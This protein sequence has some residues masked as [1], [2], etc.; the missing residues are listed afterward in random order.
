VPGPGKTVL[1]TG[2][3]RGIG[4]ACAQ[5]LAAAGADLVLVDICADLPGVDYPMGSAG[6][7]AATA[8]ECRQQGVA[9]ETVTGDVRDGPT[10]QQAA[11]CALDRFG[12]IDGLVNC[13]GIAGPSG[14]PVYEL[15]EPEWALPIGV[16]L[17]GAWQL[18]RAVA[19]AMVRQRAGSIVNIASTAGLVGYRHFAGYVAS[20][21]GL[22][23]LTKAA[24]L[25]LAPFGVR[26]NAVCPGSVRD[27][28]LVDGRML[29]AVA[30]YLRV[31]ADEYES[32]F[33][34]Q[35][36]AN[37]LVEPDDVAG[38]VAWLLGDGSGGTTGSTV[39]VD[40][41]YPAR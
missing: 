21:H 13:A 26:V 34:Q 6:Q 10:A 9:V 37:R 18:L 5:R 23:G 20:K 38:A 28:L 7:L 16:N 17:T 32:V 12:R 33:R 15:A 39:V 31:A 3:A 29:G 8:D 1:V 11:D 14:K 35:Q 22:V 24:A 4:R 27:D 2:A 25:D 40:G 36:P 41:G 30:D 19:P